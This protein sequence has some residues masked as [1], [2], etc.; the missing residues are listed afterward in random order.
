M[1]DGLPHNATTRIVQD[2]RGYLW[3]ATGGGLARFDGRE[4]REFSPPVPSPDRSVRDLAVEHGHAIV[5]L[6]A[7]GG[8]WRFSDGVFS[9]HPVNRH[10]RAGTL[11]YLLT[12]PG[13]ALWVVG[14]TD[15]V[16]YHEGKAET[17]GLRDGLNR[18]SYRPTLGVDEDGRVWLAAGDY[19]GHYENGKLRRFPDSLGAVVTVG[20]A[21][22]GGL[23]VATAERLLRMEKGVLRTVVAGSEWTENRAGLQELFEDRHGVLWIP[24]RRFGLSRL[25]RGRIVR[26]STSHDQAVSVTV[27]SEDNLWISTFGGGIERL[28]RQT[29][30]LHDASTG[31]LDDMS[32]SVCDDAS[33][34]LWAANRRG[35][36]VRIQDGSLQA[37]AEGTGFPRLYATAVCPD[38][39]NG[40]WVGGVQGLYRFG[41]QPGKELE[42][43]G[44]EL[45]EAHVLFGAANGDMWVGSGETRLGYFRGGVYRPIT[46]TEG[47]NL[48]RV[49]AIVQ[50][51]RGTIH[52]G[53]DDRQLFRW[54]EAEHRL[55]NLP[56]SI[57]GLV[58][59]M[60]ADTRGHV[61]V[62]TSSGLV[63]HGNGPS[64]VFST[65]DGLP[66]DL[67]SQVIEDDNG[68][69]WCGSR[70]GVFS[71]AVADLLAVASGRET[72]VMPTTLGAEEGMRGASALNGFQPSV[73]KARDG[74]LWFTTHEGIFG[75]DPKASLPSATP[76]RVF[77][78]EIIVDQRVVKPT[79]ALRL[80]PR[81]QQVEFRFATPNFSAP[82]KIRVRHR[83][84][85]YD[86]GW[87]EN[88][89]QRGA[90]YSR[91]PPGNYT[92]RV[93]ASQQGGRWAEPG[94]ALAFTV[95]PAWWQTW[96]ARGGFLA[97]FAGLVGWF[98]R[99]WSHRRLRSR[100]QR[101]EHEHA[102][103]KERARIARDLHDDLGGSLT[104]IGLLA[105]R[106]KRQGVEPVLQ[107]ALAQLAWRTR[108]LS[109]DLES[110][111]WT[112]SPK[113]NTLDRLAAFIA[114]YARGFFRDTAVECV[115]RGEEEIPARPVTPE[116]QHH[117]LAILKEA[118]NNVLK[119]A[120]AKN[121]AV[122]MSVESAEFVLRIAD[123][124]AGFDLAVAEFSER[125][126]LN[127]MRAR[128]TDLGSR[129][130][131]NSAAGRGTEIILRQRLVPSAIQS[132]PTN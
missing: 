71:V 6:P 41:A 26:T 23:W 81:D 53:T 128:A 74:R 54:N 104:Q 92:L 64:R 86:F 93:A 61:W 7:S 88:D 28:R 18:R 119:H 15:F 79:D 89:G 90:N 56:L 57:E 118:L 68:R 120:Q 50:D 109:G 125:N 38:R 91:L 39:E 131:I 96:W 46:R 80:K 121:V 30:I 13:G 123:D 4:F 17:F 75:V 45:A 67:L 87:I 102:L 1:D 36:V 21:R 77:I 106:L 9:E 16:R 130:E 122:T 14:N 11:L 48:R 113:N 34:A 108:R 43:I 78:D 85:G 33:G 55:E 127:N 94:V 5:F 73:W 25:E 63:L 32:T 3:I 116:A 47:Y 70:R 42:F 114:Q 10:L 110:I 115:V 29:F 124:G 62:A 95:L 35:G 12:E 52:V 97:G 24:S 66:D 129:L 58:Y 27:D 107:P 101:L 98:V 99:F 112:V 2:G 84:E 31:L 82:E 60:Y 44:P 49:R 100:L 40:I 51:A 117:L 105:D 103:E 126:G 83:L 65:A 111:V 72:R 22:S 59:G 37:F 132:E 69:L 19:L 8:V 76:P 20:T